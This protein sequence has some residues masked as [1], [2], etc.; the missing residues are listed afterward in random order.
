MEKEIR[1]TKEKY[2]GI[3]KLRCVAIDADVCFTNSGFSHLLRKGGKERIPGDIFRRLKLFDYVN[4]VLE[5][6][7]LKEQRVKNG[8]IFITIQLQIEERFVKVIL[9]RGNKTPLH[10]FSIM[11]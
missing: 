1:V 4:E 7:F 10:F 8:W 6:G 5:K 3:K 11:D 9:R 2:L